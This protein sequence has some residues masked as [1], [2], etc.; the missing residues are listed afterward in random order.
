MVNKKKRK[1]DEE[2][3]KFGSLSKSFFSKMSSSATNLTNFH[4][5]NHRFDSHFHFK[6]TGIIILFYIN[7]FYLNVLK[8]ILSIVS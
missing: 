3:A 2:K 5:E 4:D 8:Q 6:K 1:I 7:N